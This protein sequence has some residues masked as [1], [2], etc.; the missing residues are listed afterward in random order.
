MACHIEEA[1]DALLEIPG[2]ATEV[3][4]I[5]ERIQLSEM[6]SA[7]D[8]TQ[9]ELANKAQKLVDKVLVKNDKFDTLQLDGLSYTEQ[10]KLLEA[11]L[12]KSTLVAKSSF[13]QAYLDSDIGNMSYEEMVKEANK[14]VG[15]SKES[16]K[17]KEAV[18]AKRA[19]LLA[20][21]EDS[22]RTTVNK[23]T[24][25]DS[26]I[27]ELIKERNELLSEV[28]QDTARLEEINKQLDKLYDKKK[29]VSY[30]RK[31]LRDSV[32]GSKSSIA[33]P[34]VFGEGK[35]EKVT[36]VDI[37]SMISVGKPTSYLADS[38]LSDEV[39]NEVFPVPG[40]LQMLGDNLELGKLS[41]TELAFHPYKML[42]VAKDGSM[43]TNVAAAMKVAIEKYIADNVGTL[44]ELSPKDIQMIYG[45]TEDNWHEVPVDLIDGGI[46]SHLIANSI[47]SDIASML[48]LKPLVEKDKDGKVTNDRT[49]FYEKLTLGLGQAAIMHAQDIGLLKEVAIDYKTG[50]SKTYTMKLGD[51]HVADGVNFKVNIGAKVKY[52]EEK[53]GVEAGKDRE[54]LVAPI[55]VKAK[56]I[57]KRNDPYTEPSKTT[58]DAIIKNHATK[59]IPNAEV[60]NGILGL[61]EDVQRVL[62]GW[63]DPEDKGITREQHMGRV[64]KNRQ[65]EEDLENLQRLKTMMDNGETTEGVYFRWFIGKNN[66][67]MIDAAGGLNPQAIKLHR[68]ALIVDGAQGTV[69]TKKDPMSETMFKLGVAQALGFAVDKRKVTDSIEFAD[70]VLTTKSLNKIAKSIARG[71]SEI[72]LQDAKGNEIV[73]EVEELSHAMNAII[74]GRKYIAADG[75]PFDT[76]MTM[77]IDGLTNGF[78]HKMLQYLAV[79]A[80]GTEITDNTISWLNKAG[81]TLGKTETKD[82]VA[83]IQDGDIVDAYLT[84]GDKLA[85]L[86]GD[87][88]DVLAVRMAKQNKNID[89][90]TGKLSEWV[91]AKRIEQYGT[92]NEA[93]IME[94]VKNFL[95]ASADLRKDGKLTKDV[96]NL[97]KDPFMTSGYGAGFKSMSRSIGN[98]MIDKAM[99]KLLG[100]S[101][102][103]TR[104]M[105]KALGVTNAAKF[106][107]ELQTKTYAQITM[108]DGR[109]LLATFQG[110]VEGVYGD[111]VKDTMQKEFKELLAINKE[112]LTTTSMMYSIFQ[113]AYDREVT[114]LGKNGEVSQA[115]KMKIVEKLKGIFP[116]LKGP[117][118]A[119]Y[120]DGISLFDTQSNLAAD[121]EYGQIHV[122]RPTK[123]KGRTI[124]ATR[125]GFA[126]PGARA[127]VML[128]MFMDS[129]G[130]A[131]NS[132]RHDLLQIFDA[133]VIGVNQSQV[134]TDANK[135]FLEMGLSENWSQTKATKEGLERS[136]A[137]YKKMYKD[138]LEAFEAEVAA[139]ELANSAKLSGKSAKELATDYVGPQAV[140]GSITEVDAN[141]Q[142]RRDAARAQGVTSEQF[143][144]DADHSA[145]LAPKQGL[146][147]IPVDIEITKAE[148]QTIKKY[149][150]KYRNNKSIVFKD[151]D[152]FNYTP[153]T[154]TITAIAPTADNGIT[155]E[156][157]EV[158]TYH[159]I[160][161]MLTFNWLQDVNNK[162]SVEYL[163]KAL[164]SAAKQVD[165]IPLMERTAEQNELGNRLNYALDS[166][167]FSVAELVAILS[168]EPAIRK[169][170]M[171]EF[172]QKE[173]PILDKI[174]NTI[175]RYLGV[176]NISTEY[177]VAL[178]D[179][180][181]ELGVVP[182]TPKQVTVKELKS[183]ITTTLDGKDIEGVRVELEDGT[184]Y[185]DVAE[186]TIKNEGSKEGTAKAKELGFDV[187]QDMYTIVEIESTKK[188][189]GSKLLGH[190]IDKYNDKPIVIH[191]YAFGENSMPQIKLEEW[192]RKAGFMKLA[193]MGKGSLMVRPVIDT[194]RLGA[195]SNIST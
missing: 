11:E 100:E 193:D 117:D 78:A 176:G 42:L 110:L 182:I 54:I 155:E 194:K 160:R 5:I 2:T 165:N 126:A 125:K 91:T 133:Y 43:N 58:I 170:F 134:A 95:K 135:D 113:A 127:M 116:I 114:K 167:E 151:G 67:Q 35:A 7:E 66:R 12:N 169:V 27:N 158:Y 75:K 29:G 40:E 47:A 9:Q 145:S 130:T 64:G 140:L 19:Q 84:L 102:A 6:A 80:G 131:K 86:K 159:E 52:Y 77:E 111:A 65:I 105:L 178:V 115:D 85:P 107:K 142:A 57:H 87:L 190:I 13:V 74:E 50:D 10:I 61:K 17:V 120:N 59:W 148:L 45:F 189:S 128:T 191:A 4:N 139:I 37:A 92:D 93:V 34:G 156:M 18:K 98:S 150:D 161:H 94:K 51:Q 179:A 106:R 137:G 154:N 23:A 166:G 21:L 71:I 129:L 20:Q 36:Q 146:W 163:N 46:P 55:E 49:E 63:K 62:L 16:A 88:A 174:L 33:A 164:K 70:A 188:G 68:Y 109:S 89:K 24:E 81:I 90:D 123:G 136:I 72:K 168:S 38:K 60:I 8:I 39:V 177:T 96:R 104:A 162:D 15:T 124:R 185:A 103:E 157:Y 3:R 56:D 73:V 175:K 69:D 31:V 1:I 44:T 184:A 186:S 79:D 195:F 22:D 138:D 119:N 183:P 25:L 108:S 147:A 41:D 192:Y 83:K 121:N 14:E 187:N 76:V 153:E 53:L 149:N 97:M 30:I 172:P 122:G 26:E 171:E 132:I 141:A 152:E 118:S 101:T 28:S 181:V 112:I 48:G 82:I 144:L 173:Q 143:V 32:T 180:I 99:Q